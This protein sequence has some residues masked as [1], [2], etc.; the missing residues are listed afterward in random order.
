MIVELDGYATH[1][2][3]RAF[4][5]DRRRDRALAAAGYTV[6]RITWRQLRDEPEAVARDLRRLL[7]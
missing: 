4:E 7:A 1:G 2:R 6:V 5:D 3:R